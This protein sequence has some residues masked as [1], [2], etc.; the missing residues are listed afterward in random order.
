MNDGFKET[1]ISKLFG[2]TIS[3][4]KVFAESTPF[5]KVSS[6][7]LGE[8]SKSFTTSPEIVLNKITIV[9]FFPPAFI[10]A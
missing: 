7:I 1:L 5:I 3:A 4:V 8:K 2:L 6:K 10:S 9:F